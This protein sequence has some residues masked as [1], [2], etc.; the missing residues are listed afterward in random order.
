MPLTTEQIQDLEQYKS[1]STH[2]SNIL[3]MEAGVST[4]AQLITPANVTELNDTYTLLLTNIQAIL[5]A[6]AIT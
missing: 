4:P 6:A 5:S 1:L 2:L 3:I